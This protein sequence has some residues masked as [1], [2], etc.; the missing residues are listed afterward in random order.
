MPVSF[1]DKNYGPVGT[2]VG[3]FT[4]LPVAMAAEDIIKKDGKWYYG[5]NY[6]ENYTDAVSARGER[7]SFDGGNPDIGVLHS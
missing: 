6:Y 2:R 4:K 5:G 7:A 3:M 1:S